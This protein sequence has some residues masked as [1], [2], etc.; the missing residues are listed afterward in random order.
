MA[1]A[2]LEARVQDAEAATEAERQKLE[3]ARMAVADLEARVQDAE[4]AL[5]A[6]EAEIAMHAARENRAKRYYY[7][8]SGARYLSTRTYRSRHMIGEDGSTLALSFNDP[9]RQPAPNLERAD[10]PPPDQGVWMAEK[11]TQERST[12]DGGTHYDVAIIYRTEPE[13]DSGYLYFGWWERGWTGGNSPRIEFLAIPSG[14][15]GIEHVNNIS[16]LTGTATY[17]GIAAG[18][19]GVYSPLGGTN[20]GGSFTANATLTADF[21][22][23]EDAGTVSGMIDGFVASGQAQDWTVELKEAPIDASNTRFSNLQTGTR[24]TIAGEDDPSPLNTGWW[25]GGFRGTDALTAIFHA[26]YRNVGRMTGGLGALK[27]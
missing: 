3:A 2:D 9:A 25:G 13:A 8:V 12:P 10:D 1:V 16:A 6:L 22:T 18:R 15:V 7:G 5:A 23:A 17:T 14:S 21:G 4:V 19:Y 26:S 27:E 24:W 20:H 11:F